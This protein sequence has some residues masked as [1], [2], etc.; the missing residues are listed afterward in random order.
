[1]YF[2]QFLGK[3]CQDCLPVV[4]V[5]DDLVTLLLRR[6][7]IVDDVQHSLDQSGLDAGDGRLDEVDEAFRQHFGDPANLKNNG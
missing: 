2:Y 3:L 1:M 4:G 6:L 5:P 7:P